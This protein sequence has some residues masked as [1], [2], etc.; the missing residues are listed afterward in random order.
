MIEKG[1]RLSQPKG[2]SANG[3]GN[4]RVR[5]AIWMQLGIAR[6]FILDCHTVWGG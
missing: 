5:C 1:P 3:M 6:L 2:D 4:M